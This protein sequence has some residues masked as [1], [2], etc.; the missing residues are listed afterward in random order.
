MTADSA[1]TTTWIHC[2]EDIAETA[3]DALAQPLSTPFLEWSWL[4]NLDWLAALPPHP[5]AWF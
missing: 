2:I 5:L 1:L 4:N 3:W